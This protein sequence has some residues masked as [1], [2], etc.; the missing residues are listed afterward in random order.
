MKKIYLNTQGEKITKAKAKDVPVI[1]TGY[2]KIDDER[3]HF[4]QVKKESDK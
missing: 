4:T 2:T 1:R 3:V